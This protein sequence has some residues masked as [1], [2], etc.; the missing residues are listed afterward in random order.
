MVY[1]MMNLNEEALIHYDEVDALMSQL[2]NQ[3]KASGWQNYN[4]QILFI[5]PL[6]FICCIV[7][8]IIYPV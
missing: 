6:N 5:N 7:I 1:E 4:K 2:V 8:S 3:V